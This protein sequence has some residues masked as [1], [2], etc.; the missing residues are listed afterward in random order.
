[1]LHPELCT[2]RV[3][4]EGM[5]QI[6]WTIRVGQNILVTALSVHQPC[7][8]SSAAR[9]SFP[10]PTRRSEVPVPQWFVH[11][12]GQ[13][14]LLSVLSERGAHRRTWW[15]R[16]PRVDFAAEHMVVD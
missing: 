9:E 1:M 16:T 4:A 6:G 5:L 13:R 10:A 14:Y 12:S 15:D 7:Q 2:S 3:I 8:L 11:T